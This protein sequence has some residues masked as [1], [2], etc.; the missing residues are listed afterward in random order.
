[1]TLTGTIKL[2]NIYFI[3]LQ[4]GEGK[5][6]RGRKEVLLRVEIALESKTG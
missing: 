3:E 2:T 4:K 6:K 1:M 5:S